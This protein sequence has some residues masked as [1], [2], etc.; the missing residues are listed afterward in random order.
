M[1]NRS[2]LERVQSLEK[3]IKDL[4]LALRKEVRRRRVI[5]YFVGDYGVNT[6]SSYNAMVASAEAELGITHVGSPTSAYSRRVLG[7]LFED[8]PG[9]TTELAS[10]AALKSFVGRP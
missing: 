2:L 8:R 10:L 9:I 1:S 7:D 4:S 5:S 6:L 3:E